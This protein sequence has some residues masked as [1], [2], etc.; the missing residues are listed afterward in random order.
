MKMKTVR[1]VRE[2]T[3]VSA[4]TLRYYDQIGLLKPTRSEVGYRL[5]DEDDIVRLKQILRYRMVDMP[6]DEI[7]VMLTDEHDEIKR[8]LHAHLDR[9][10]NKKEVLEEKIR[11]VEEMIEEM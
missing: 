10:V 3:G 7:M 9:L 5:Y 4:R 8:K 1:E 11:W 2:L 6:L